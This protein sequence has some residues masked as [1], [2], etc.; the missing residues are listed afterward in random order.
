VEKTSFKPGVKRDRV[1]DADSVEDEKVDL[2]S[3]RGGE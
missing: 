2:T 1:M 3:A